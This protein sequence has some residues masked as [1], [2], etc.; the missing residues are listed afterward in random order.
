MHAEDDNAVPVENCL[1]F[2]NALLK[3]QIKAE[4]HLYQAGGHGFRLHNGS[5]KDHWFERL[6]NWMTENGWLP[7]N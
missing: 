5:L 4:M 1:L 7:S 6:K 3:N 2:Y